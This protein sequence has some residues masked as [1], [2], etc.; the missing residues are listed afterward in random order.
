MK[1]LVSCDRNLLWLGQLEKSVTLI[2]LKYVT[3][4]NAETL[5]ESTPSDFPIRYIDIGSVDYT[6][7]ISQISEFVFENSP[8]RARRKVSQGDTIVSTVRTYLKAITYVE[9]DNPSLIASTGFAVLSPIR[10]ILN[11]RYLYYWMRSSFVVDEI[12]ARSVGV[13]YP[14]TNASEIGSISIPGLPVEQQS[15]IASFLDHKIAAIATLIA[16]KQRLIQLLEEKR[17]ALINQAVTK[18]LNPNVPMKDSGIPWIGKIPKQW[19]IRRFR[20]CG[21][22]KNGQVDPKLP[23][24]AQLPLYAPN[25]IRSG[26]GEFV[27]EVRSAAE[28][29]AVSGKYLVEAGEVV[30][31]KIRPELRKVCIAPKRGLCSAD[32]YAISPLEGVT[33]KFLF[34]SLLSEAFSRLAILESQRVAMPKINRETIADIPLAIPPNQEQNQ[35]VEFIQRQTEYVDR[36]YGMIQL[37]I[38]L[39]QEY[40]QSLITAAVTGKID[41]REE[42]TA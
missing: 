30:Y 8:S 34:W 9:E 14:A 35:I 41:I 12:C 7:K 16:K 2:P 15:A 36:T 39:L 23:E 28:Q 29:G 11:P 1:T 24:F 21:Q 42:V 32:M 5:P 37:Q 10:N 26:T 27:E 40:R 22:I 25:H 13:S 19:E 18:G 3:R 31:S 38:N 4:I 20:H 33:S 17:T 6:G